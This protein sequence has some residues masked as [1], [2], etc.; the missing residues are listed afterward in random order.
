VA[1][2][3]AIDFLDGVQLA[4]RAIDDGSAQE[5]LDGLALFSNL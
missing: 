5:K 1:S 3:A 4:T 2:G